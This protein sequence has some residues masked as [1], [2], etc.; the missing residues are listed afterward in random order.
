MSFAWIV[1]STTAVV[2]VT[3][4]TAAAVATLAYWPVLKRLAGDLTTQWASNTFIKMSRDHYE[5]TYPFQF[6]WYTII[7]PRNRT[8][9]LIDAIFCGEENVTD[10]VER[11]M[12]PGYNFHGTQPTPEML[13]Y[14]TLTF[15]FFNRD[16]VTF[17]THDRILL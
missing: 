9:V 2:A 3:T 6:N 13:G 15:T 12:G 16:P 17:D 11:Y 14:D 1:G 5:I 8:P 7:V 10:K 4:V